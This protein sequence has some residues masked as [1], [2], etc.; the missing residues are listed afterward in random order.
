MPT[1]KEVNTGAAGEEHAG[2]RDHHGEARDQHGAAGGRGG[3]LERRLGA[4]AGV[5]LLHLAPQVEHAVVDADREAD[6]QHDGG[7][8]LVER[9]DL[10]DRAE[11]PDRAHHR[12]QREQQRQPGGDER[13]ERDDQ[14]DQR[15]RQREELGLLEVVLE[16]LRERLVRARVAELLDP[17][18][19]VRALRGGGGGERR[20]DAVLRDVVLALRA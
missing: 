19:G 4:R 18:L 16:R 9:D 20:V 2:H 3:R 10:G 1:P 13:A 14:D 15:D 6:E 11:Q 7:D 17:Q 5:A 12:G 8:R